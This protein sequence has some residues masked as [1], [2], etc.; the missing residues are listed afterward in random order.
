M[1]DLG[2]KECRFMEKRLQFWLPAGILYRQFC[3]MVILETYRSGHNE[4]DSKS[5]RW[6]S[7]PMS[8]CQETSGFQPKQPKKKSWN[9]NKL[10]TKENLLKIWKYFNA[11]IRR[12]TE[13]VITRLTR[14]QLTGQTVRGFESHRLRSG[15]LEKSRFLF[16]VSV[17]P[18]AFFNLFYS[19]MHYR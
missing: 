11:L 9:A 4:A 5:R 18:R 7:S 10:L 6:I 1:F 2:R 14:N 16:F 13:V 12:R 15:N 19:A 8:E 3:K 17:R